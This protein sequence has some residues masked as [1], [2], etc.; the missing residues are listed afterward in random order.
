[1]I[2]NINVLPF[3]MHFLV[4]ILL[5]TSSS[6]TSTYVYQNCIW[7]YAICYDFFFLSWSLSASWG[8]Y[9]FLTRDQTHVLGAWSL[10][11]WTPGKSLLRFLLIHGII[12]ILQKFYP[13]IISIKSYI[14]VNNNKNSYWMFR[15]IFQTCRNVAVYLSSVTR[16][17]P[18]LCNPRHCSTPGFPV[19]HQLLELA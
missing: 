1:M 15:T 8:T 2:L 4:K 17:C 19:Y 6:K 11:H 16:L 5:S 12:S 14:W 13:N 3:F 7:L 18:T 9:S 10:N